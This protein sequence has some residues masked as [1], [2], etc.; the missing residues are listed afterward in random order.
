MALDTSQFIVKPQEFGGLYQAANTIEQKKIRD[1]KLAQERE[2]RQLAT[3]KFLQDYLDPKDRLTGTNYDPEI[4]NQLQQALQQGS[5]LAGKGA[6]TADIMM[7]LGPTVNRINQYSTKAKL[8]N[9]QIKDSTSKLKGYGGY[10]LDALSDQAKKLAFYD[11]K[12]KLKDPSLI[13]PNTDWVTQATQ[14]NPEIVTTAAGLDQFV[15]KTPA[16]TYSRT[17]QT[18]YAGR[19]RNVKYETTH[20]FWEDLARDDQGNI[21]TDAAGNPIGLDVVG[22]IIKDD[23]GNPI[24]NP[25]TNQPYTGMDKGHFVAIMQHNPDVADYIRGQINTHF[26]QAGAKEVPQE[27]SPQW[28][29]MGQHILGDEL[30]GRSKSSFKTIDQQKETGAAVKVEIGQSPEMLQ[31]TKNYYE[32]TRKD[33]ADKTPKTTTYA[34]TLTGIMNNSPDYSNGEVTKLG[35]KTV[36][37][38]TS[39]VPALKYNNDQVYKN[40]YRDPQKNSLIVVKQNGE[41]EEIPENKVFQFMTKISGYNK[42]NPEYI[43]KVMDESGFS[44]G[45]F[46]KAS[47]SNFQAQQQQAE[48]AQREVQAE[49]LSS[50]ESSGKVTDVK[51]FEGQKTKDGTIKKIDKTSAFNMVNDYYIE[52]ANGS[53]KKFKNKQELA[54]YLKNNQQQSAAPSQSSGGDWKTRAKKI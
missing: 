26:K 37:D 8:I 29:A 28:L 4:V 27:G 31:A 54:D 46:A 2:G 38:V 3:T 40:V 7:A 50:F 15:N 53:E 13:D 19:S 39:M 33:A 21:K 6:S 23:K 35:D 22:G 10:N 48:Q 5:A 20:P 42:L 52:F 45:K 34:D 25:E 9:Q 11:D 16:A 24:I 51:A 12:G 30:R 14:Q 43:R 44:G 17:A 41:K 47:P 49:K 32:A 18:T 1:E 36:V